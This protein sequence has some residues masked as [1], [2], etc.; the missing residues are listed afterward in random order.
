V[1]LGLSDLGRLTEQLA[2][3]EAKLDRAKVDSYFPK[4]KGFRW[5][6]VQVGSAA[7]AVP[8][9]SVSVQQLRADDQEL[10]LSYCKVVIQEPA[11]ATCLVQSAI[12]AATGARQQQISLMLP[13]LYCSSSCMLPA[14]PCVLL[15]R[16]LHH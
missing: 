4:V 15:S 5:A 11:A 16:P 9:C 7:I 1:Q 13:Q 2:A 10:Q 3:T 12:D 8:I 6:L 14:M